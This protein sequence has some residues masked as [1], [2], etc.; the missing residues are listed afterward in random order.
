[1]DQ[2]NLTLPTPA[3]TTIMS[4]SSAAMSA[5]FASLGGPT[6]S[7][8]A[9]STI[10]L[11]TTTTAPPTTTP[12]TFFTYSIPGMDIAPGPFI[13]TYVSEFLSL[14]TPEELPL[15][16]SLHVRPRSGR[17]PASLCP[18]RI[19]GYRGKGFQVCGLVFRTSA[20]QQ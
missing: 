9:G 1:M 5:G 7:A 2:R 12:A 15:G 11:P 4:S 10:A 17:G 6:T 18:C 13:F 8:L 14:I 19:E 3:A 20:C 16:K